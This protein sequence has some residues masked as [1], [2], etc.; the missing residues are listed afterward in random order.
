VQPIESDEKRGD[1]IERTASPNGVVVNLGPRVFGLPIQRTPA[2]PAPPPE[3]TRIVYD[4]H[5]L[6]GN[7]GERV[8]TALWEHCRPK[9]TKT[10]QEAVA[11][12]RTAAPSL[13]PASMA[14]AEREREINDVLALI[15]VI[16]QPAPGMPSVLECY[17]RSPRPVL[18]PAP[19]EP[20]MVDVA[21]PAGRRKMYPHLQ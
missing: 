7:R 1:G 13:W 14:D 3:E 4:R 9:W 5:G 6:I 15:G 16:V 12:L 11:V 10:A 2:P 17:Y 20:E 8:L 19:R 18:L 21:T